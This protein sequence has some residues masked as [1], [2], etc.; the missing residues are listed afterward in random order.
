MKVVKVGKKI[1]HKPHL[2]NYESIGFEVWAEVEFE[3]GENIL[4]V[5]DK[6]DADLTEHVQEDLE[7]VSQITANENTYVDELVDRPRR[8]R[9]SRSRG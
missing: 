9:K 2:G 4:E 6:I 8:S 3:D 7:K 1:T 5:L